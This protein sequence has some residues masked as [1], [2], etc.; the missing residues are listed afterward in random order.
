MVHDE[1]HMI[2]YLKVCLENGEIQ[3]AMKFLDD[4]QG[5]VNNQGKYSWTGIL[6][7]DFM[8]SIK[9]TKIDA[10]KVNFLLDSRVEK[11]PMKDA[12]FVVVLGN[13]F[14][15]AIEA[16][17]KC[18]AENRMI[19]LTMQS[20]NE[21][22]ILLMRN[23]SN[24]KPN[25]KNNRFLT[26]KKEETVKHGWGIESVKR[27]IEKYDGQIAFQYNSNIFEVSIIVND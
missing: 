2:T 7:L 27:I 5:N 20:V 6:T 23:S 13:L 3:N 18:T 8:L 22:F 26:D 12:D 24:S 10:L 11:V 14:D 4:Y 15:N 9:K 21:M 25:M 1:K 16:V 19:S 17:E